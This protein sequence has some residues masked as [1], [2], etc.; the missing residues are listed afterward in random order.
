MELN[1]N[2]ETAAKLN[3]LAQ[4][5]GRGADELIDEAVDH[6]IAYDEWFE[7]KVRDGL[8]AIERGEVAPNEEVRAWIEQRESSQF[9]K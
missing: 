1:L 4:R 2:P 5:T 7:Q 6:L 8:A 3:K 9:L